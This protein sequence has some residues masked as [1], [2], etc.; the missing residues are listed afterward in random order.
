MTTR[1]SAVVGAVGGCWAR[2]LV[3]SCLELA[4]RRRPIRQPLVSGMRRRSGGVHNQGYFHCY[5]GSIIYSNSAVYG[6]GVYNTSA[7][8]FNGPANA[9]HVI[10]NTSTMGGANIGGHP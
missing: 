9:C 4:V 6:G 3:P 7:G 2:E 1:G 5:G 10:S 8:V